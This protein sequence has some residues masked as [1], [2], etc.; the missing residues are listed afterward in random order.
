MAISFIFSGSEGGPVIIVEGLCY[1]FP[2]RP[3]LVASSLVMRGVWRTCARLVKTT[4]GTL[5]APLLADD[6]RRDQMLGEQTA[7]ELLRATTGRGYESFPWFGPAMLESA[8]QARYGE[9]GCKIFDS[10]YHRDVVS[11]LAPLGDWKWVVVH[12]QAFHDQQAGMLLELW[13]LISSDFNFSAFAQQRRESADTVRERMRTE[14]LNR[15]EHHWI[16]DDGKVVAT[17]RPVYGQK[18]ITH[19]TIA[20]GG[21]GST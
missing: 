1:L 10:L 8:I 12:P 2:H 20:D 16:G 15:F 11:R 19:V 4:A 17:T 18:K 13:K 5:L 7:E 21:S 3:E 6:I 9:L 14:F